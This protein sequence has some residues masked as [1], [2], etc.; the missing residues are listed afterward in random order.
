MSAI[1]HEI[2]LTEQ[3]MAQRLEL[4]EKKRT[5][6]MLE[7]ALVNNLVF[8]QSVCFLFLLVERLKTIFVKINENL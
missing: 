7:K 2:E 4:E 8:F 6:N 3:V 1:S 5:I